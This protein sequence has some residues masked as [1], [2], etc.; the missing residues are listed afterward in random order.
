ML[1]QDQFSD[2]QI[3]SIKSDFR[4]LLPDNPMDIRCRHSNGATADKFNNID[5]K[6]TKRSLPL[7]RELSFLFFNTHTH[8]EAWM[9]SNKI[10]KA[11]PTSRFTLVPKDSRGPRGI[12]IEPH[13][14]MFVQQGLMQKLYDHIES[15]SPAKGYINFTDQGT[16][17]KLA[18]LGSIDR[19]Y[20]TI[21]LKDA[22]DMVSWALVQHLLPDDWLHVVTMCR[23]ASVSV[24]GTIIELKKFAP[25]GSA[26]CFP[27]EA[28]IFWSICRTIT[29]RVWVY[30]DD[31]I[32]HNE[33]YERVV[34]ALESYG[35]IINR[36][37]S[38]HQG[39]FRES[40]GSEYY[41]GHDIS[42][43][44][45]KSYDLE[46][47]IA[48]ANN[49]SYAYNQKLADNIVKLYEEHTSLI[50]YREPISNRSRTQTL[51]YYTNDC[52]SSH[53]FFKRKWC[54][55]LQRYYIRRLSLVP[56][57]DKSTRTCLSDGYDDLYLWLLGKCSS[58]PIED[59]IWSLTPSYLRDFSII[60]VDQYTIA[61]SRKRINLPG[62]PS[63]LTGIVKTRIK[64]TW[65]SFEVVL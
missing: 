21:D 61:H 25:M 52:C 42:Y 44:K 1:V 29:D 7:T 51:V 32:V 57:T 53:V 12:C 20:C 9:R 46:N 56:K 48:F 19:S 3:D 15:I 13:E 49:V 58:S 5:R 22:S 65:A 17:Q 40:C 27:I 4:S 60:D 26:L 62:A 36:D 10:I 50:M 37:K 54:K 59:K 18:Y 28:M 31:I 47:Y 55:D 30:G 6:Y 2:I 33:N 23:S 63:A 43:V 34:K 11:N 64:F 16:N 14:H 24:N 8:A 39:F 41:R 38:L 45:C 35:L